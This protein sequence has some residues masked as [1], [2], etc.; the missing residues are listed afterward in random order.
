MISEDATSN[1]AEAEQNVLV[2]GRTDDVRE[3]FGYRDALH[4][5]I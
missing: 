5:E 4:Q 3:K 1:A 2:E